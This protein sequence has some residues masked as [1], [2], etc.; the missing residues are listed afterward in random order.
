MKR[1]FVLIVAQWD[2][3]E[4]TACNVYRLSTFFNA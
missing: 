1:E 3:Q 4:A 2:M